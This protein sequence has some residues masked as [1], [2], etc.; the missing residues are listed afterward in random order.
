M[1]IPAIVVIALLVLR[2]PSIPVILF[3]AFLGTFWAYFFQGATF[4][5]AFNIL[6]AG[7]AI[8]FGVEF[9]DSLFNL[10]GIVFMLDVIVLIILD[11]SFG[12][13]YEDISVLLSY[14][15]R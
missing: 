2:M 12:G 5:E 7:N 14:G 15:I 4:L 8:E 10:G 1:L 11:L 6:Y 9:I 13:L 3:G